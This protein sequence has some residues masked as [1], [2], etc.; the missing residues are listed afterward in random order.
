MDE[1]ISG[2]FREWL[3]A[4]EAVQTSSDEE[5]MAKAQTR[6]VGYRNAPC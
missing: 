5:L 1:K 6:A 2:L 3:A 4:F